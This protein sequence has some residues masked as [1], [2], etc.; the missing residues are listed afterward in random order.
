MSS[1]SRKQSN[2]HSSSVKQ[3]LKTPTPVDAFKEI[4]S[5]GQMPKLDNIEINT[6]IEKLDEYSAIKTQCDINLAIITNFVKFLL[7][8]ISGFTSGDGQNGHTQFRTTAFDDSVY[9]H[10]KTLIKALRFNTK[11][12]Q[13]SVKAW[14]ALHDKCIVL[15]TIYKEKADELE[16]RILA[17]QEKIKELNTNRDPDTTMVTQLGGGRKKKYSLKKKR[18]LIM[19]SWWL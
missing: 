14:N 6:V 15:I 4:K 7:I 13:T 3:A 12:L 11:N 16:E 1:N 8:Y 5:Y 19:T 2:S 18:T 10:S 9:A 17:L